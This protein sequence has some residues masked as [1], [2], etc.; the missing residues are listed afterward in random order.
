MSSS[1]NVKEIINNS[2]LKSIITS[3]FAKRFGLNEEMLEEAF[4]SLLN[5]KLNEIGKNLSSNDKNISSDRFND[6]SID[7]IKD[8]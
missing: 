3:Q 6:A 8:E 7:I 5:K 2:N 4:E 1:K